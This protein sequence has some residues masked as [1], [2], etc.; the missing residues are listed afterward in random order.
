M[1]GF[2]GGV[3]EGGAGE[4][5]VGG[6]GFRGRAWEAADLRWVAAAA[7][8]GPVIVA[9][10]KRGKGEEVGRGGGTVGVVGRK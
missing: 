1:V 5:E 7:G 4:G 2:R 9:G 8:G 10:A 6:I 3:G